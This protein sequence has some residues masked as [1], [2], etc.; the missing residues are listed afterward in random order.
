[1]SLFFFYPITLALVIK[2]AL[3]EEGRYYYAEAELRRTKDKMF[4]MLSADEVADLRRFAKSRGLTLNDWGKYLENQGLTPQRILVPAIAVTV[5]FMFIPRVSFSQE[6][7]ASTSAKIFTE[8]ILTINIEAPPN[9]NHWDDIGPQKKP[10]HFDALFF[11]DLFSEFNLNT[12]CPVLILAWVKK[13][14]PQ[15]VIRKI[16]HVPCLSF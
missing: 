4:A 15:E 16:E 12:L 2:E 14:R 13:I 7:A 8:K 10:L 1:M 5:L 6:L 3:T 9:T 11:D